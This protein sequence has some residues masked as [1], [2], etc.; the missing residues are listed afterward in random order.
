MKIR[1]AWIPYPGAW[2]SAV[3]LLLLTGII[4]YSARVMQTIG[5]FLARTSPNL[6]FLFGL[7][8]VLLPI[9]FVAIAHHILHLFLDRFFPDSQLSEKEKVNGFFP[10]LMSWWEGLYGWLVIVLSTLITAA[11]IGG[12]ADASLFYGR[13]HNLLLAW[14]KT[15]HFFSIPAFIWVIVSAYLYQFEHLVHRHLMSLNPSQR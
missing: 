8:A 6:L 12:F 4:T 7:A 11:L 10:S 1:S 13:L 15:R 9:V 3:L 5:H 14:D 2:L